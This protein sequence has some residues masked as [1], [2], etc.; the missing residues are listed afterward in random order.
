MSKN[1]YAA[2]LSNFQLPPITYFFSF[3]NSKKWINLELILGTPRVQQT[4][5]FPYSEQMFAR[6][7]HAH[8]GFYMS[9]VPAIERRFIVLLHM[10]I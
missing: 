5:P 6:S 9:L 7:E 10:Q 2:R 1:R 8:I 4:F 3:L